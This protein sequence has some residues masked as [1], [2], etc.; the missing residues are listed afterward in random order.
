M[1]LITQVVRQ[2]LPNRGGVEETVL[3]LSLGLIQ[4]GWDV[5]IVTLNRL[6]RSLQTHLAAT[7]TVA[8][9]PVTRIPF[10]GSTRYPIAPQVLSSSRRAISCMSTA[11]TFL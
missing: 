6:F 10:Q 1:P 4:L 5:R 9:L 3:H 8:G 11:S 2:F 7:E